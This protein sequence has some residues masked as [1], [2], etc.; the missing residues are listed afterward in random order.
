[1]RR[2]SAT[3]L[4]AYLALL[5][6]WPLTAI[7]APADVSRALL[8]IQE[9][10]YLERSGRDIFPGVS[11]YQADFVNAFYELAG[12]RPVWTDAA[13]ARAMI[14]LLR[15]SDAE[16][17]NPA[18]Y[19]YDALLALWEQYNQPW[20]DRDQLRAQAEMLLTDGI[21]LYATHLIQGKV[22]PRT[23]DDS[24]NYTRRRFDSV[25]MAQALLAAV[26]ERRVAETLEALKPGLRF[27]RLMR[28]ALADYR[29]RAARESFTPVPTDTVLRPG[30]DHPNV[31]PLRARLAQ[32]GYLPQSAT[33]STRFDRE[34]E[35][36]VRQLQRDN[37]LDEDGIVGR[38]CFALMNLSFQERIDRLRINLD[39]VRWIAQDISRDFIVVN[40][41][42]YELYYIRDAELRWT[43][44][45]MVGTI[46][47]RTPIFRARLQYLEFNPTWNV[48]R[49]IA[50]RN[51]L[52]KFRANPQLVVDNG[53][54]L[55][56]AAGREVDPKALDWN[57]FSAD[58]F[59]YRVV[60]LPGPLNAMGQVKFM[61]PNRHAV[62]L[63]DTPSRALFSRSE[64]A[65]S[66]GCIRVKDPL[67]LARLL[68]DDPQ[69]WTAGQIQSLVES[70]EPRRNVQM[71]R[72]VD[73]MLMY[74][75]VSPSEQ[76]RLRFNQD[77]YDLDP[78]ALRVLDAPPVPRAF[79]GR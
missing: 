37:A 67:E 21:L 3:V 48:P 8:D 47:T 39:R 49:S 43:T 79:N 17:L 10:L 56:D 68:L 77:V 34:L 52:P 33:D 46:D 76:Q 64:R 28:Q 60:Q 20:S 51:L 7:P 36:A 5:L 14:D 15:D 72:E 50:G 4:V 45:V 11:I 70:G 27:Y 9:R 42:G 26:R 73:V 65:F 22:D 32:M 12:Y 19:H 40:I 1:V 6:G 66:A 35:R 29:V 75:T 41:A 61:F 23:L 69:R 13:Y 63:H 31:V 53:Y 62:Y 25:A 71:E 59:P 18:D 2:R 74:W 38:Q 58:N 55:Y 44:P 54:R 16:G 57:R 24:W 30:D 78:A